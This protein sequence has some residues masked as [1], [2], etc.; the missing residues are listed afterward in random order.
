MMTHTGHPTCFEHY[1]PVGG[2]GG[3]AI[4][5]GWG[6]MPV[7]LILRRML[8][9]NPMPDRLE[10]KPHLPADWPEASVRNVFAVGTSVDVHYTRSRGA[11]TAELKNTGA[12][13]IKITA[14]GK[15]IVIEPG[16]DGEIEVG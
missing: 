13:A 12:K 11:L 7:D 16:K 1:D 14:A 3:G 9:L 2:K 6:T 8:G 10:L 15:Q 5:Q 4:D